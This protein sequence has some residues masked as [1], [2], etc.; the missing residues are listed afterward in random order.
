MIADGFDEAPSKL[1]RWYWCPGRFHGLAVCFADHAA[2]GQARDPVRF[3]FREAKHG[4]GPLPFRF[5]LGDVQFKIA[6][7]QHQQVLAGRHLFPVVKQQVNNQAVHLGGQMSMAMASTRPS[8]VN[9]M[10]DAAV[11]D[12]DCAMAGIAAV[13]PRKALTRR[14]RRDLV[15]NMR[16]TVEREHPGAPGAPKA[17]TGDQSGRAG[18]GGGDS[19]AKG[20]V[21][22][23]TLPPTSVRSELMAAISSSEQ[24]K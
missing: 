19:A 1:A 2:I 21:A 13:V 24:A 15:L 16:H 9:V 17:G 5:R 10:S 3:L 20:P 6:S 7:I 18:S 22:C 11:S 14:Q 4:P 23:T 8:N 12:G